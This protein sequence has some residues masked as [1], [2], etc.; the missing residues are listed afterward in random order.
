[1]RVRAE[2]VFN[3]FRTIQAEGNY[4]PWDAIR[5]QVQGGVDYKNCGFDTFETRRSNGTTSSQI[6]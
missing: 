1:M 6:L 4:A 2:Y 5:V 3:L